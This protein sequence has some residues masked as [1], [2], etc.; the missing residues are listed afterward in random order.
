MNSKTA[1]MGFAVLMMAITGCA[2]ASGVEDGQNDNKSD[3]PVDVDQI[4]HTQ[5]VSCSYSCAGK[6]ITSDGAS[7]TCTGGSSGAGSCYDANQNCASGFTLSG[8]AVN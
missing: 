2:F 4:I 5:R 3:V 8:C 6:G 1:L 7:G